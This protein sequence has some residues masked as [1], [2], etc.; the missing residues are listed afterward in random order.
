MTRA[1]LEKAAIKSSDTPGWEVATPKSAS[2]PIGGERMVA[3]KAACQPVADAL[4]QTGGVKPVAV[5]ERSSAAKDRSGVMV[6]VRLA[7]YADGGADKVMVGLANAA[8]RCKGFTGSGSGS[9]Q[10]VGVAQYEGYLSSQNS[11][12]LRLTTKV[13][14]Q[15]L[16]VYLDVGVVGSTVEYF[17]TFNVTGDDPGTGSTTAERQQ[18]VK[19]GAASP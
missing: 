10:H 15:T 3:D 18:S 14:N 9:E 11:I 6:R 16:P 7:S 13:G 12:G 5:V 4:S 17:A 8:L 2:G 19:L 1:Q